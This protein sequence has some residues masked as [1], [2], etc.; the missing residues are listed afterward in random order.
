MMPN[1]RPP[2]SI[3]QQLNKQTED[4]LRTG[5]A[6]P[7]APRFDKIRERHIFSTGF[8]STSNGI[9]VTGIVAANQ[10]IELFAAGQ[11]QN[12]Q[13]LPAGLTLMETDTNFFGN[14][15]VPDDQALSVHEIGVS[16]VPVRQDLV[17]LDSVVQ[18]GGPPTPDD[19]DSVMINGVLVLKYLSSEK[20]LGP[21]GGYPQPGGPSI[22]APTLLS[23][24]AFAAAVVGPPA[25]FAGGLGRDV[26]ALAPIAQSS[27]NAGSLTAAPSMRRRLKIPINL[28][29]GVNFRFV[30]R[31][32][33]PFR[34]RTRDEGGT[35]CLA[36]RVDLYC[37]ES[38]RSRG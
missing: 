1:Q 31:F 28:G 23:Q 30:I 33:R 12:G 6:N 18:I 8:L 15:R 34:I 3:P 4:L 35:M 19:L 14:G 36:I 20:N 7:N 21:L 25:S 17:A 26:G 11:G 9:A 29:P 37:A 5:N 2:Q 13:G 38:F 22:V 16:C 24:T 32:P 27:Q 10:G